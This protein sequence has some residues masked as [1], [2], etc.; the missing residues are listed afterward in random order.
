MPTRYPQSGTPP[1]NLDVYHEQVPRRELLRT[2]LLACSGV[3]LLVTS[4]SAH[5]RSYTLSFWPSQ[6]A[7]RKDPRVLSISDHPC[8]TIA[9]ARVHSL[10]TYRKGAAIVSEV[11]VEV[12]AH[13]KV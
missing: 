2:K 12:N 8:G 11:V 3:V 6:S 10:P 1:Q 7:V 13:G 5:D 4:L 9:I